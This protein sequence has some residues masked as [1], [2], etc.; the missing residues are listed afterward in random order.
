VGDRH[1]F[2][3]ALISPNF[4]AL[5][6][7]AAGEGI[8]AATR[9]DLVRDARVVAAYQGIVDGVN[10]SLANYETIKRFLLVPEEW[11]LD[12]GEL[13]PSLKL[14]RRVI[15]EKY[16]AEI[17]GFYLDRTGPTGKLRAGSPGN[18]LA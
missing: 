4:A 7:W 5:E 6:S 17:A 9:R 8:A 1:K 15:L 12:T 11:S 2:A 13:T 14:K 10:G 18:G 16:S 3:S